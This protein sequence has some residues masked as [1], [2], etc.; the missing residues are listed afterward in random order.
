MTDAT[1]DPACS[2]WVASANGHA[3]FPI[4][5]LPFG[6]FSID[7]G[8]PR[9]GVA[10]GDSILDLGAALEA[11]LFSGA[12]RDA[13]AAGTGP[14]LNP[15]LALSASTRRALRRRVFDILASDSDARGI[16]PRL[17]HDAAVCTLHLPATIGDYTDFF[18][19][20]HHARKGGQISR[21][22]NPLMPNYKYVPVAYHSR[23]SSVRPSGEDVR[24]PNGQRRL[25]TETAPM[26]GP[27]RNLDYE[28]EL[29]VWIGAGNR[30]DE[31]IPIGE[32]AEHI[33]GFCLLNDWSARDIQAW[34][35]QPLG[36]FMGKSFRTSVSPWI[37]TPEAMEPFRI[38]QPARPEGDPP[39]LPHLRYAAD[40]AYGAFDIDCEVFLATPAMRAA[41]AEPHRLCR[42]NTRELYW[43][44][45]QMVAHHSSNGC[46]LRPGDLFGSGTVS[47]TDPTGIGCL[48]EMTFGGRDAIPLT[49]GETRRY[50]EDGDEVILR[51]HCR[52]AGAAAIG[53]GECRGT[54]V[55][56]A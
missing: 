49:N 31:P 18:A 22:D 5:N 6:V 44:V 56:A 41:G 42:S 13:A 53:F 32:A 37:I 10:I 7:G 52:R 28:L 45:A 2:S 33:A 48:L 36:P 21:P 40:Q 12:V 46:N 20:I 47:G 15:L 1:H 54:V 34:E 23:A 19:G 50:L 30:Q 17:L 43:T 39:P 25:P 51:A 9:G 24:R 4:Q 38:A 8:S 29:G 14:A 16:A 55:E 26:F 27:C 35:S 3:E 11:G